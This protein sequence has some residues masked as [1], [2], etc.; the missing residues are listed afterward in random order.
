MPR[1]AS[2]GHTSIPQPADPGITATP[3]NP[4]RP[5]SGAISRDSSLFPR[6]LGQGRR[7]T[8]VLARGCRV[9]RKDV[10]RGGLA[11]TDTMPRF[12]KEVCRVAVCRR[13]RS[14]RCISV[15][16]SRNSDGMECVIRQMPLRVECRIHSL[17]PERSIG[18]VHREFQ[19]EGQGIEDSYADL[20][21][22]S[23][24]WVTVRPP[25]G[26]LSYS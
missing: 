11:R 5:G 12:A 15:G 7:D 23:I 24:G 3:H 4:R 6:P 19:G 17:M 13:Y 21:V 9:G 16:Q 1:R 25:L 8:V 10:G 20:A 26:Y 2:Q 22:T 14:Y 18:P